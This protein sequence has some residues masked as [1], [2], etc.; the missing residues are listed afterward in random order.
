MASN[1]AMKNMQNAVTDYVKANLPKDINKA[2]FGV[3]QGDRV[4][5]GNK[6]Y[7]YVATVDLY[8][9]SGDSVACILPDSGNIAA[10]VGV[11]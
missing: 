7:G 5:I 6:S 8:F 3:V 4:I 2:K 1:A 11:L 10:V 9:E